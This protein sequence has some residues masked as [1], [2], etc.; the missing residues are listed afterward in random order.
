[1]FPWQQPAYTDEY[2]SLS[3]R[4]LNIHAIR[5]AE[6]HIALLITNIA[7]AGVTWGVSAASILSTLVS[8]GAIEKYKEAV[9]AKK[10]AGK[11]LSA[12]IFGKTLSHTTAWMTKQKL[13]RAENKQKLDLKL[14]E[15]EATI[16]LKKMAKGKYVKPKNAGLFGLKKA[17]P[18][19]ALTLAA[20][21]G[22]MTSEVEQMQQRVL[23][24]SGLGN[25]GE[26]AQ[27]SD[28][29][30]TVQEQ[31]DASL[32]EVEAFAEATEPGVDSA[33][34]FSRA[35]LLQRI[36][37]LET[38]LENLQ[39]SQ[40]EHSEGTSAEVVLQDVELLSELMQR[41]QQIQD[42]L[43]R[44]V[45]PPISFWERIGVRFP[46]AAPPSPPGP[47][48][49]GPFCGLFNP[50]FF[51]PNPSTQPES[52]EEGE[53]NLEEEMQGV[54][55]DDGRIAELQAEIAAL[56]QEM[57]GMRAREEAGAS[58]T[59]RV[60][61]LYHLFD[62]D[63]SGSLSQAELADA[64][65]TIDQTLAPNQIADAINLADSNKDGQVTKEELAGL[66]ATM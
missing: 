34:D 21:F 6:N 28:E 39:T 30:A 41:A 4:A 54:E 52:A 9:H 35:E 16:M 8:M 10:L 63:Q 51:T 3:T 5:L 1:M 55:D 25:E 38:E 37:E 24:L 47:P 46:P 2:D 49:V 22:T 62:T 64:L 20:M 11:A 56:E 61:Q 33:L 43:A 14:A 59:R 13:K 57:S 40:L 15:L 32:L 44:S 17:D 42:E 65:K 31:L 50:I 66:V 48:C 45:P 26:L 23:M 29:M 53:F 36:Q 58:S 12:K 27:L 19:N 60:D 18:V 7:L